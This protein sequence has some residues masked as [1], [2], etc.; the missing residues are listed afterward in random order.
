VD[1]LVSFLI[2]EE[3]LCF[4]PFSIMLYIAFII[5]RYSL[6]I[7]SF[8]RVFYYE[9]WWILPKAFYAAI[10]MIMWLLSLF[11][12]MYCIILLICVCFQF[13]PIHGN[14]NF[15]DWVWKHNPPFLFCGI[16]WGISMLHACCTWKH[17]SLD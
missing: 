5:L 7:P 13:F 12:L 1:I 10:A 14:T 16:V 3:M 4:T 9:G 8:F 15:I 11:L 17:F 6:S 2:L